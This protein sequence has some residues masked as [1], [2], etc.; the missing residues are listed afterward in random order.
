MIFKIISKII[1]I[2]VIV[3]LITL[4]KLENK[5]DIAYLTSWHSSSMALLLLRLFRKF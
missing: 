3:I 4:A 1:E 5:F 2:T